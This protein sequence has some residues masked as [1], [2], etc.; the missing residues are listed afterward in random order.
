MEN[1]QPKAKGSK[2]MTYAIIGVLAVALIG[3]GIFLLT[4]NKGDNNGGNSSDVPEVVEPTVVT[5]AELNG[6][7]AVT[8]AY[9][10][11]E[12]MQTL[13][14][15]IQNGRMT[16][17]IVEIDGIVS[18]PGTSYSITEASADGTTKIGTVF[19]IKDGS[20]YPEDGKRARVIAKVVEESAMNFQLA[21]LKDFVEEVK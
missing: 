5:A 20:A 12:A 9:G 1:E 11:Y 10:D 3:G 15:D 4:R 13:A 18:H 21:T 6:E 14:S 19:N 8:I 2:T 16:G 7:R 17:K